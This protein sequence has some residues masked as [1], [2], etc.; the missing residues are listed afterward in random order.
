MA[1]LSFR[2][3]Y[4]QINWNEMNYISIEFQIMAC[5]K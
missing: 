1:K 2:G 5:C 3:G 4:S